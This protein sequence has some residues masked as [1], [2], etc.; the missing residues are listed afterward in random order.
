MCVVRSAIGQEGD[1]RGRAVL[2]HV[3]TVE[4]QTGCCQHVKVGGLECGVYE[5][6]KSPVIHECEHNVWLAGHRLSDTEAENSHED[7]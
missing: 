2:E 5:T 6:S 7:S 1:A 4:D 3:V